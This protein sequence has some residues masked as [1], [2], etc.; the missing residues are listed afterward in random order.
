MA[1]RKALQTRDL[2]RSPAERQLAKRLS[3]TVAAKTLG[4]TKRPKP[5]VSSRHAP[6][7][8]PQDARRKPAINSTWTAFMD[9]LTRAVNIV[10]TDDAENQE[11]AMRPRQLKKLKARGTVVT[12]DRNSGRI[13]E[14][15]TM[16]KI[17][18]EHAG[19]SSPANTRR[20]TLTRR[21]LL[22]EQYRQSIL[23]PN[24]RR[25]RNRRRYAEELRSENE[26]DENEPTS[27]PMKAAV[28]HS[29]ESDVYARLMYKH[30]NPQS[31]KQRLRALIDDKPEPQP[32]IEPASS[33]APGSLAEQLAAAALDKDST[34]SSEPQAIAKRAHPLAT[35]DSPLAIATDT[36]DASPKPPTTVSAA[37]MP[38][39]APP[40]PPALAS[41]VPAPPPPPPPP[42]AP[43]PPPPPGM[44][45][46]LGATANKAKPAKLN[47]LSMM[48]Q[49]LRSRI[50]KKQAVS[51]DDQPKLDDKTR[52]WAEIQCRARKITLDQFLSAAELKRAEIAEIASRLATDL[53]QTLDDAR[54]VVSALDGC[55]QWY[56]GGSKQMKAE[57]EGWQALESKLETLVEYVQVTDDI[58][59]SLE[60]GLPELRDFGAHLQALR[61]LFREKQHRWGACLQTFGQTWT[62]LGLA[63]EVQLLDDAWGFMKAIPVA[64]LARLERDMASMKR[65]GFRV[66]RARELKELL[67]EALQ[68]SAMLATLC[69]DYAEQAQSLCLK[70][71]QS[72]LELLQDIFDH[73]TVKQGRPTVCKHFDDVIKRISIARDLY[74]QVGKQS[75]KTVAFKDRDV[76]FQKA[77]RDNDELAASMHQSCTSLLQHI[78]GISETTL[79][80][81]VTS[82]GRGG[83]GNGSDELV[84]WLMY[85]CRF[86]NKVLECFGPA[87]LEDDERVR[88][89]LQSLQDLE[90]RLPPSSKSTEA[91]T[92]KRSKRLNAPP[93]MT[94]E[95]SF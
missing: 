34:A 44:G 12:P 36:Q 49:R 18:D 91:G 95:S 45:L 7:T 11:P 90:Y 74:R 61:D 86:V 87:S 63:T 17:E 3:P 14:K 31:S 65:T 10:G 41:G 78:V 68:Q 26:V 73:Y 71:L 38:P 84:R 58:T 82:P 42:G 19:A 93:S 81:M 15:M 21:D 2:N 16:L 39:P 64:F 4:G 70:A 23:T 6:S 51:K 30:L 54:A 69:P 33:P 94:T 24:S 75:A 22:R 53:P 13:V 9:L 5:L 85:A 32:E 66:L 27:K 29:H 52:R 88:G 50:T 40:A 47:Q 25:H 77:L 59:D 76:L 62:K 56:P 35:T 55:S 57:L 8:R 92:P 28:Q 89:L 37:P 72:N 43:A 1:S 67:M 79:E 48:E 80:D 83:A 46:Q 20:K 60:N